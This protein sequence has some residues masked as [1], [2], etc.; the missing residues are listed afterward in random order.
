MYTLNKDNL[1]EYASASYQGIRVSNNDDMSTL[2]RSVR[3]ISKSLAM[4]DSTKYRLVLN[5][6]VVL[7]NS[8]GS[9]ATTR[10]LFYQV[11]PLYYSLLKTVLVFLNH[12]PLYILEA[13]L[14]SIELDNSVMNI[15]ENL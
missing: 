1:A 12:L 7:N 11:D 10:I 15:L 14:D 5:N 9:L 13:D 8:F 3:H 2:M 4:N 6:I